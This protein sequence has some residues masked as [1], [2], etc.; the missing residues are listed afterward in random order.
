MKR[1]GALD[2][3]VVVELGRRTGA[4]VCASLLA[5]LG[6]WSRRRCSPIRCPCPTSGTGAT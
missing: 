1:P 3:V 2:G 5:Q 6:A 4:S